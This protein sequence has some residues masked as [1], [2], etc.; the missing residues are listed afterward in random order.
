MN[1]FHS[2]WEYENIIIWLSFT[3]R[4]QFTLLQVVLPKYPDYAEGMTGRVEFD[5]YGERV[6]YTLR[7]LSLY[8]DGMK[9]VRIFW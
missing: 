2:K 6:N 5:D 8:A 1:T 9:V 3:F 4:L 7:L